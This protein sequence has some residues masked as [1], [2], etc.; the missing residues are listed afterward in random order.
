MLTQEMLHLLFEYRSDGV[1]LERTKRRGGT[2]NIGDI[3]GSKRKDGYVKVSI[4][5]KC[6][7]IHRLIYLYHHGVLPEYIDHINYD[8]TD[9]R[10]ENLR[11]A[12]WAE[13]NQNRTH[14]S[15]SSTGIKGLYYR[16]DINKWVGQ[17]MK[18]KVLHRTPCIEDKEEALT[19]L[20]Q[21]R[22]KL[23]GEFARD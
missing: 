8:H 14:Q 23:H 3:V 9:N 18:D 21:L 5:K 12:T 16:E 19:A 20:R 6:Y 1:L 2:K 4:N 10:I 17:V 13:N 22:E 11:A 15:N 7:L